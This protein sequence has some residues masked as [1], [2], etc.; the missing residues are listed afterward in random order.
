M[1]FQA[2]RLTTCGASQVLRLATLLCTFALLF[3]LAAPAG[4]T[5]RA[6]GGDISNPMVRQVD[7]A[8]PAVVR[9]ATTFTGTITFDL[10][11][12]S[13]P[14]PGTA[15]LGATGSGAFITSN[16]DVLTADHVV[17]ISHDD[18]DTEWFGSP[19]LAAAIAALL[20]ANASCLQLG[21]PL[22]ADDILAGYVQ[23][24]G[25]P[26]TTKYSEPTFRVWMNT[27]YSGALS[28]TTSDSFLKSLLAASSLTATL[29]RSSTFA[30][31]DVAILHVP[32]TDT[33]YI[34][35]GDSSDVAV[36]DRLTLIGFPGNADFFHPDGTYDPSDLL[37]PSFN[38]LYVSAIKSG[39][40]GDSLIQ[41]GGN[42]EHG[43]SGGPALNAAGE[44][45]GVV[46]YSGTD[47]PVGTFFLRTSN[48]AKMLAG[49]ASLNLHGGTFQAQ[50]A[51]AFDDYASSAA[52]HWHTAAREL[53]TL[54]TSYPAFRGVAPYRDFATQAATTETT[55]ATSSTR[56]LLVV[57]IISGA[58][59]LILVLLVVLLVVLRRGRKSLAPAYASYP[60]YGQYPTSGP[61]SG[62]LPPPFT[63]MHLP[64]SAEMVDLTRRPNATQPSAFDSPWAPNRTGLSGTA[65]SAP[66]A[67]EAPPSP[68]ATPSYPPQF[69][70]RAFNA[71]PS[72]AVGT[73][74]ETVSSSFGT[75][76]Q[77]ADFTTPLQRPSAASYCA[78][79]HVMPP[80]EVYCGICGASRNAEASGR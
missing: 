15:T 13:A 59:L 50:W 58:A 77:P 41:V 39:V 14:L 62:Q 65:A 79:G 48:D 75:M 21:F 44:I 33:P 26:Y 29:E 17:N 5:G 6:P 23:F 7:I 68:Q 56:S 12:V 1:R 40:T 34:A 69:S 49:Q 9:I 52:G 55:T 8:A 2:S 70:S 78:N 19:S 74:P 53:T 43:D 3:A 31:D 30:N 66:V 25:I 73:H 42:V 71:P 20:N 37:T 11:G 45:V 64:T 22:T 46:S 67:V 27:A 16:G 35:L 80:N 63:P 32:A 61:P 72:S 60:S 36:Q 4:A 24:A 47:T 28:T 38:T 57:G 10:C 51:Q 18:L 76:G 54:S